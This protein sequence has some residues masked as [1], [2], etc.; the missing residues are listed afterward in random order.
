MQKIIA[1]SKNKLLFRKDIAQCF[2]NSLELFAKC[3]LMQ[4]FKKVACGLADSY[5]IFIYC[6]Y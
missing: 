2:W 3:A 4:L 5:R 1:Y 6:A